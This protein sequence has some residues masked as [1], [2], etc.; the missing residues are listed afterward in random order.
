MLTEFIDFLK[1]II[2]KAHRHVPSKIDIEEDVESLKNF[3]TELVIEAAVRCLDVI[4]P[5]L[6]LPHSLP[7]SMSTRF[8]VGA[9]IAQA[10]KFNKKRRTRIITRKL[11]ASYNMLKCCTPK[12]REMLQSN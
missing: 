7:D 4:Q 2:N 11:N 10:C 8:R 3:S 5:G 12:E 9:S 6:G 1:F